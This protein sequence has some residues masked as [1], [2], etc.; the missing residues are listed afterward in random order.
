MNTDLPTGRVGFYKR[1]SH[2]SAD[3]FRMTV[4][5]EGVHG[6]YPHK[7][8]DPIVAGAHL[9]TSMQTIVSRNLDPTGSAVVTIG[10]F[11]AGTA[12]NVIPD[13]AELSGTVRTFEDEVRDMIIRRMKEIVSS[14]ETGF[15]VKIDFQ[16]E[17][18][19]P[20]VINDQ[21]ATSE[22]YQTAVGILGEENVD[23]LEPQMGGEDF[24]LYARIVPGTFMRIGCGNP[25]KG[26]DQKGHSPYFDVDE[27]ALPVA[28]DIFTEAVRSYLG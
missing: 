21:T 8:S 3:A 16:Y 1:S 24:G 25:D 27:A 5:G 26:I 2:A 23:Y 12:P 22:V 20:L 4:H 7:G 14:I 17:D 6:A 18:G 19:V 28:V 13:R 15:Q 9:V 11:Q 10:Q